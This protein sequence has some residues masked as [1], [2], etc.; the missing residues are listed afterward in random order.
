MSFYYRP[1]PI[2]RVRRE[3]PPLTAAARL[4]LEALR[5]LREDVAEAAETLHPTEG[6]AT[7]STEVQPG[8]WSVKV[9]LGD[10]YLHLDGFH[11]ERSALLEALRI[12]RRK[13]RVRG[14]GRRK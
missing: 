8:P 4:D 12:L 11:S 10:H 2:P 3:A 5:A 7:V 14:L 1:P 6:P 9:L 13:A